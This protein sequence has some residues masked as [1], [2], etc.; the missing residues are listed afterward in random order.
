MEVRSP[1]PPPTQKMYLSDACAI[2]PENKANSTIGAFLCPEIR[3]FTG[4]GAR[5]LQPSPRSLVTEN[6]Y[7]FD[8]NGR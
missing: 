1:P 8:K 2:P 4:F 7:L 6:Y 3:A 5:G